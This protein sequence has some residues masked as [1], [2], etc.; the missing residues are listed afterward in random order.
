[1]NGYQRFLWY[2]QV[3]WSLSCEN[4]MLDSLNEL[5]QNS[6]NL[7]DELSD[8]DD[9]EHIEAVFDEE[10][11][12]IEE[13]VGLGFIT[14]QIHISAVV[15]LI[16]R[17]HDYHNN[18]LPNITL[19]TSNGKKDGLMSIGCEKFDNTDYTKVQ[20]I[21]AFANYA[22]HKKEWGNNWDNL[23]NRQTRDKDIIKSVGAR[24]GNSSNLREGAKTLGC[25]E[26]YDL[27][28]LFKIINDWHGRINQLYREELGDKG[29]I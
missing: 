28:K 23:N 16:K 9:D 1:M 11:S 21:N 27:K 5:I 7:I 24:P 10:S 2:S 12:F 15:S 13:L 17:M 22:K 26:A 6:S 4:K 25:T 20:T 19:N 29:L 8:D 18:N 14:C 3:L